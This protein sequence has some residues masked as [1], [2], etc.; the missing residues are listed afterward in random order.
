[1][2]EE[3]TSKHQIKMKTTSSN[4]GKD[5]ADAK[6]DYAQSLED[7]ITPK[8]ITEALTRR[9]KRNEKTVLYGT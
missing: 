7:E 9:K 3:L 2:I 8:L 1:M 5:E 4:P 6:N